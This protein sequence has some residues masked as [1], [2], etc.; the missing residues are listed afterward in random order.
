MLL[1]RVTRGAGN[2]NIRKNFSLSL[3]LAVAAVFAFPAAGSAGAVSSGV[4]P[5]RNLEK[6]EVVTYANAKA[7]TSAAKTSGGG[8]KLSGYKLGANEDCYLNFSGLQN[9]NGASNAFDSA[10]GAWESAASKDLIKTIKQDN[11]AHY[12]SLDGK[13]SVEFGRYAGS[14]G[15]IAVTAYWVDRS[16]RTIVEF[17]MQYNTYYNWGDASTGGSGVM[18]IQ[19]IATHEFGHAFGL[20]DIYSGAYSKVTMYGY[21]NY[22]ETEKRTLE[23]QDIAGIRK[24]YGQ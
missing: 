8:Y 18:D 3:A 2:M 17:D 21:S 13:N 7:D 14:N 16:T 9:S 10:V 12:G 15:V 6:I 22:G 5:G 20:S 23:A 19:N 11:N 1:K 4:Y 24:I